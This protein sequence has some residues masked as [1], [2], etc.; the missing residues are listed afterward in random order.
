MILNALCT[1][2][3]SSNHGTY[4]VHRRSKRQCDTLPHMG[5]KIQEALYDQ[6]VQNPLFRRLTVSL[7]VAGSVLGGVM[8][9]SER[10]LL[11]K[12]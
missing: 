12:C 11:R 3:Q 9:A 8:S 1:C 2:W 4:V 6:P 10:K 7:Q 5:G